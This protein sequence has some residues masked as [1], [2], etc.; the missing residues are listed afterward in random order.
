MEAVVGG[1]RRCSGIE[2]MVSRGCRMEVASPDD[3]R[4]RPEHWDG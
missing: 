4:W 3:R 2:E 1:G